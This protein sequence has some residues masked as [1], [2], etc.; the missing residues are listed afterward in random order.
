MSVAVD[1]TR[2]QGTAFCVQIAPRYFRLGSD[3]VAVVLQGDVQARDLDDVREAEQICP[4][5]AILLTE[6]EH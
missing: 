4:T 3:G 6:I 2:C 1:R 5:Q